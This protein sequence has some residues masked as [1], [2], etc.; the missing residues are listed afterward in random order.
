[1]QRTTLAIL[2]LPAFIGSTAAWA[3]GDL[4]IR[5]TPKQVAAYYRSISPLLNADGVTCPFKQK[6]ISGIVSGGSSP[7]S[8][9][10]Q[11]ILTFDKGAKVTVSRT[12]ERTAKGSPVRIEITCSI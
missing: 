6:P 2:S 11:T 9:S 1:M 5:M 3:V 12:W 10:Q 7:Q 4:P 8:G